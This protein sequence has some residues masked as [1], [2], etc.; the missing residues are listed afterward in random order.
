MFYP[1]STFL[2]IFFI[3]FSLIEAHGQ[4]AEQDAAETLAKLHEAWGPKAS[5]PGAS[6]VIKESVRAGQVISLRLYANGVPKDKVYSLVA[7]PVTQKGP[8]EQLGGVMLDASGLAICAGAPGTCGSANKPDDPIDIKVQPVPGEPVRLGLVS[9]DGTKVFAKVVPNP[10]RAE[11]RGCSV[12][13]TLLTPGAELVLIE[14]A[15]FPPN[16]D[17]TMESVSEGERHGGP[18]KVDTEGRYVSAILPSVKGVARDDKSDP[19]GS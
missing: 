19:E 1:K 6:L 13:A 15:G 17:L 16:S 11:D 5:T 9:A 10:L 18:G 4:S 2:Y 12:D 3:F 8:S 14:G 7:W